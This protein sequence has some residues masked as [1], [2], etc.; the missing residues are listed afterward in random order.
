M[1]GQLG[2][3]GDELDGA[4][5]GADNRDA[6]AAQVIAV[7][8]ARRMEAVA[9]EAVQ[10]GQAGDRRAVELAGGEDEHIGL[11]TVPD[12][13]WTAQPPASGSKA[14]SATRD[15]KRIRLVMP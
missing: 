10:P 7:V 14:Q 8:P 6:L 2:H 9:G 13:V 4:G 11:V 15:E 3:L 5:A 12:S 1:A